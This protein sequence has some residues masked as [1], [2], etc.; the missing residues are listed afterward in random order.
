MGKFTL[1]LLLYSDWG[2]GGVSTAFFPSKVDL[3]SVEAILQLTLGLKCLS[4]FGGFY[5][6][7]I[8]G[9]F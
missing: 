8:F 5:I 4:G 1:D 3:E 6:F 9:Y 7:V 2:G